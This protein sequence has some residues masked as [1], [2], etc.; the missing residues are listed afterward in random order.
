MLSVVMLRGIMLEVMAL[1]LN[2]CFSSFRI[3]C[4]STCPALMTAYADIFS[5]HASPL[6][7]PIEHRVI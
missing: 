7:Q 4:I 5:D 2:A 3:K 1:F 6:L